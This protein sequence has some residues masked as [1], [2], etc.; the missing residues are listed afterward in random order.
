MH[1]KI[2]RASQQEQAS[3]SK[4]RQTKGRDEAWATGIQSGR[5]EVCKEKKHL[6]PLTKQSK[7]N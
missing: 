6:L 3:S 2:N 7:Y 4:E 1:I 5:G